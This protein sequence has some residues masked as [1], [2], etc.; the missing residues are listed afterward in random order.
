MPDF[1]PNPKFPLGRLLMTLNLQLHCEEAG[2]DTQAVI[3]QVLERHQSS[4]WGNL[5][6]HDVLQNDI[7]LDEGNRI[8][9]AYEE[10][11]GFKVWIIT[12]WDRSYTTVMLPEDY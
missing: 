4:D 5:D 1:T 7:A 9:S 6:A 8:L 11:F 3:A 10:E 12:E 2:L